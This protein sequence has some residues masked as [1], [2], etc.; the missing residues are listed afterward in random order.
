MWSVL[1]AILAE[2]RARFPDVAF[3]LHELRAAG[4]DPGGLLNGSLDIAFVRPVASFHAVDFRTVWRERFVVIMPENHP[5]ADRPQ[6]DLAE[7]AG[8]RFIQISRRLNPHGSDVFDEACRAAGFSPN[9]FDESDSPT[10]L[11]LVGLGFGVSVVPA[12]LQQCAFP[13]AIFKPLTGPV[14]EQDLVA[15]FRKSDRSRTLKDFLQTIEDV[16][17]EPSGHEELA[18]SR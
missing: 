7:L 11:R 3:H 15:A 9:I 17:A 2:H 14:L 10:G 4:E 1:P 5:L 6:V 8:E 12:A 18:S 13:G 16:T